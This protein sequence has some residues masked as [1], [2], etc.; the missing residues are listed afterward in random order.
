MY[1]LSRDSFQFLWIEISV[2]VDTWYTHKY[3]SWLYLLIELGSTNTPITMNTHST[4]VLAS[5]YC[6]PVKKEKEFLEKWLILGLRGNKI[7]RKIWNFYHKPKIWNFYHKPKIYFKK[8]IGN[9]SKEP[10]GQFKWAPAGHTGHNWSINTDRR[11]FPGSPVAKISQ[12][13]SFSPWLGS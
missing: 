13:C 10:K 9:I 8:M 3:T 12:G 5:K 7:T 2:K 11:D 1:N 4:R 6:F